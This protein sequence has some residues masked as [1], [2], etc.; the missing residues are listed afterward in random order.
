MGHWN[1]ESQE[2]F[3]DG[4]IRDLNKGIAAAYRREVEM[5]EMLLAAPAKR[6]SRPFAAVPRG[7]DHPEWV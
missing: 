6:L 1:R 5:Y 2:A 7:H 4:L 3:L